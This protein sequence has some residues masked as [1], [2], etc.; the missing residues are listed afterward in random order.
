VDVVVGAMVVSTVVLTGTVESGV[1]LVGLTASTG[2]AG[3]TVMRA[4][5]DTAIRRGRNMMVKG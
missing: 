4:V 1:E 5:T 2:I 3:T